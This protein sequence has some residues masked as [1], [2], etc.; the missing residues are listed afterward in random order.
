MHYLKSAFNGR[1]W[2]TS[3]PHRISHGV[4]DYNTY[5]VQDW[6]GLRTGFDALE[7]DKI[8]PCQE[9]NPQLQCPAADSLVTTGFLACKIFYYAGNYEL[10]HI[11]T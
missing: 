2:S 11:M 3:Q 5:R 10:Q 7:K 8:Y 4:I 6:V 1:D 9:S